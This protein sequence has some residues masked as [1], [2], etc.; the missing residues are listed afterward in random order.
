M[1][2][3]FNFPL[4]LFEDGYDKVQEGTRVQSTR[5]APILL[6]NFHIECGCQFGIVDGEF[7]IV[8]NISGQKVR[9]HLYCEINSEGCGN[10]FESNIG[11]DKTLRA[12]PNVKT[13]V[14]KIAQLLYYCSQ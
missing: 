13:M 6:F 8:R 5:D 3:D 9:L 10:G 1:G 14:S 7:F 12:L 4:D 2:T 11:R